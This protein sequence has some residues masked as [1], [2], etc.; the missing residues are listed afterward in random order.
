MDDRHVFR[1]A[2]PRAYPRPRL[3]VDELDDGPAAESQPSPCEPVAPVEAPVDAPAL[4]QANAA[5]IVQRCIDRALEG[6]TSCMRLCI[7][8]ILPARALAGANASPTVPAAANDDQRRLQVEGQLLEIFA[9]AARQ[10]RAGAPPRR[11]H[12]RV[13][14]AGGAQAQETKIARRPKPATGGEGDDPVC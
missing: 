4:L 9:D 8:R 14:R 13:S 1:G 7:E 5:A 3:V 12:K 11:R 6:D 10:V 2:L